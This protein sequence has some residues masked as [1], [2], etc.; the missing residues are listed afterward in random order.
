MIRASPPRRRRLALRAEAP[1]ARGA[2][3]A[4][5]DRLPASA[6]GQPR[7]LSAGPGRALILRRLDFLFELR[8]TRLDDLDLVPQLLERSAR[9]RRAGPA[10][11]PPAAAR[12]PTICGSCS[13]VRCDSA[14]SAC[15]E[16]DR[17]ALQLTQPFGIQGWRCL[18][19]TRRPIRARPV[20][21]AGAL[22][23]RL[24]RGARTQA[25]RSDPDGSARSCRSPAH[26]CCRAPPQLPA[27][28][29]ECRR[30]AARFPG[31]ASRARLALRSAA[32]PGAAR[33]TDPP[34]RSRPRRRAAGPRQ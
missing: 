7:H 30:A 19:E 6:P 20:P 3:A 28:W 5:R 34:A 24:V 10:P 21:G 25:R 13:P 1:P 16:L 29:R 33:D 11:A 14:A 27:R 9:A 22:R 31:R 12:R 15:S 23:P 17:A 26:P 32:A 18:S 4:A 2:R 8:L